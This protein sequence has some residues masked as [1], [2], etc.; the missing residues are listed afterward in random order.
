MTNIAFSDRLT[1]DAAIG[2]PQ[3]FLKYTFNVTI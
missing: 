1:Y 3:A 2:L